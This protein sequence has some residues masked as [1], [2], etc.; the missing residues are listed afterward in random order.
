MSLNVRIPTPVILG[1]VP[2]IHLAVRVRR[3][4]LLR[5]GSQGQALG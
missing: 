5:Y 4:Q 1:L 2:R 3:Q